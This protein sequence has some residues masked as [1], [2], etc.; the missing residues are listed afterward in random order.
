MDKDCQVGNLLLEVIQDKSLPLEGIT[1]LCYSVPD[2]VAETKKLIDKGC[3]VSFSLTHDGSVLENY[4]DTR[5][6][7]NVVISFRPSMPELEKKW[8]AHNRAHPMVSDW[9]FHGLGIVVRD[10]DKTVAYYE[11]LEIADFQPETQF[12]S[13]SVEAIDE[14][15]SVTDVD[16]QSRTRTAMIGE[17]AFEFV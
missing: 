7:G 10:L 8:T 6:H 13:G 5:Q 4:V 9:Q 11:S 2:P 3:E 12:D 1:H 14:A 16:I 15:G 17:V